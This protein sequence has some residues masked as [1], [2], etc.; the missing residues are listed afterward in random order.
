MNNG[1][2]IIPFTQNI[3]Q[4]H[5]RSRCRDGCVNPAANLTERQLDQVIVDVLGRI[6]LTEEEC[7]Q[8]RARAPREFARLETDQTEER[9]ARTREQQR[10]RR[11]LSYL[12][13]NKITL[14]RE[15]AYNAGE[16]HAE[17]ERLRKRLAV[18]TQEQERSTAEIVSERLNDVLGLTELLKMAELSYKD[19][20]PERRRDLVVALV[21][22][23]VVVGGNIAKIGARDAFKP[24]LDR[25][26]GTPCG[27]GEIRTP[28][29]LRPAALA[30]LYD[31]PL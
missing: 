30:K 9:E 25:P 18:V 22:E 27:E 20:S 5:Y 2:S 17:V 26:R 3:I 15:G 8:L 7:A 19:A 12:D 11:D 6:R 28:E 29:G 10:L 23:L 1:Y 16:Y 14:L 13:E 31:R 4:T 21:T 24:L